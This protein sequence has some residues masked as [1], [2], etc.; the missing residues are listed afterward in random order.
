MKDLPIIKKATG[1][2]AFLFALFYLYTSGFG[3]LSTQSNLA[4]FILFTH[5]LVMLSRPMFKGK[6]N[7]LW[8]DVIDVILLVANVVTILYWFREFPEFARHRVGMPNDMD[9]IMGGMLIVLSLEITRRVMGW[10]LPA[11]GIGFLFIVYFGPWLP[12]MLRHGGIPL[13]SVITFIYFTDG[14][15]GTITM[16][17]AVFVMP[18]LIFGAFLRHSG[19]GDFFVKFCTG[20][21]G[22]VTGGPA[23]VSV[24]GSAIFGSITGSPIANIVGTGQFTIPLMKRVG[25]EPEFASAVEATSSVGGAFLPPIMGAGAFILATATQTPYGTVVAMAMLP[26]ALYFLAC[27]WQVYFR[28]KRDNLGRMPEDEMPNTWEELK[29][30]WYYLFSIIAVIV[31][32]IMGFSI[33]RTAFFGCVFLFVCSFFRKET[34]LIDLT[35][36]N[37]YSYLSGLS[38]ALSAL[39]AFLATELLDINV[40][41]PFLV[42]AAIL[43]IGVVLFLVFATKSKELSQNIHT[44]AAIALVFYAVTA[45]IM[46]RQFF[47]ALTIG[48]FVLVS[49]GVLCL[50]LAMVNQEFRNA[51]GRFGKLF[52][53]LEDAGKDS[54]SVGGCAGTIGIVMAGV[55]LTGLGIT[56]SAA[57]LGISQGNLFITVVLVTILGVIVGLGL[58]ITAAYIILSILAVPALVDLGVEPVVAHLICFWLSMSSNLTPPV[59]VAAITAAGIG[60]A[61]PMK[62]SVI[63]CVLGIFLYLMPF[64]MAFSPEIL[65]VG[66]PIGSVIQIA[67]SWLILAIVIASVAQGWL[68]RPLRAWERAVIAVTIPLIMWTEIITSIIGIVAFF[69]IAFFLHAQAK[70]QGGSAPKANA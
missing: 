44:F 11:I 31:G 36:L 26:A 55:T 40:V 25:Y 58:T 12:G 4:F 32:L 61:N 57:L 39:F 10:I 38:L 27:A 46:G 50:I 64:T 21:A 19:G 24:L 9:L 65:V 14:I 13:H 7:A 48:G 30:G 43:A 17:F 2:V 52:K 60:K 35:G 22:R 5:I 1:I 49:G 33:P 47:N 8:M 20:V 41:S 18:F 29:N 37:R 53:T 6:K 54:L 3:I 23:L 70:K 34:G 16:T 68:F 28:A 15:F 45:F 59:A 69:A 66:Y 67:I 56:F 63:A 51:L 62:T 42:G